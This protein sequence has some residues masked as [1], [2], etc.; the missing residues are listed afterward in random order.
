VPT[1]CLFTQIKQNLFFFNSPGAINQQLNIVINNNNEGENLPEL[2]TQIEQI[3]N[4][5]KSPAVKFLG[6]YIDPEL[7]FKYRYHTKTI[8]A[9]VSK[10]M[11]FLR[12][13]KNFLSIKSLRA[14]YYAIF[15][16]HLVYGIQIWSST[17]QS[18][19]KELEK[20]ES[21]AANHPSHRALV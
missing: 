4:N 13:A 15:H 21:C 20:T 8:V 16:S 6:I 11:Y 2:T 17:S 3:K 9:K 1:K 5:S 18:N 14:L 12:S 10:A 19:I 7:S